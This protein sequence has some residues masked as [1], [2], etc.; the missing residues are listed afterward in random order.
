MSKAISQGKQTRKVV[1][2]LLGAMTE[3]REVRAWLKQFGRL[4][5]SRFAIIKI[6]GGTLRD[7]LP[8]LC[9]ALAFLQKLGL[10]PVI[11]HGG[12]PQIDAALAK[13]GIDTP[14]VDG[15]RVTR[16]AA[17]PVISAALR[18]TALGFLSALNADGT[19]A[20]FCPADI[21]RAEL[22]D[23]DTLGRVG[24]PVSVDLDA[25]AAIAQ[26]GA[27]PILTSVAIA[28]DGHEVNVNA[29]ALV[30]ELAVGLQPMKI[31]FLTPT[32]AILDQ[33]EERI[34][35]VHLAS[36][37]DDLMGQDWLQGGMKLK[38]QMIHDMLNDLPLTSSAAITRPG[39]L[40]KELFTHSGSGTL[41]RK[42][43][44][45]QR[46]QDFAQLDAE[47]NCGLI[48][49]AFGRNLRE[50]YWDSL[51]FQFAITSDS[52]RA[53]ALVT[54][55]NGLP[56]LDKFAVLDEAR[57]EGL[58][59]AVWRE[60]RHHAPKLFWRSR[61]GNPINPFYFSEADGSIRSGDWHVFW[62]GETDWAKLPAHVAHI[63]AL[64]QSFLAEP[65][66]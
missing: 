29:D 14:R 46:V 37:Y 24:R 36:E 53:L 16:E 39:M 21:V 32:G 23:P 12:G 41:I 50:T 48:E 30:R 6:G 64:D 52:H 56:Y 59:A 40:V 33:N 63:A 11:V 1:R 4:E 49:Q 45:I 9:S 13:A 66:P 26:K 19:R 62:V 5:R 54:S 55:Q 38:L 27:L 61:V 3:G 65:S 7:E 18:E 47:I 51:D 22:I 44:R 2:E 34:S 31:I 20:S 15:L 58:G 25:I 17:M 42:G 28:E 57:G 35:V 10:A 8:T 43:E 60:L